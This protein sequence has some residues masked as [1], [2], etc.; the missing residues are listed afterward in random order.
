[1]KDTKLLAGASRNTLAQL[2][3]FMS[4]AQARVIALKLRGNFFLLSLT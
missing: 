2:A 1:M 4:Q 3:V